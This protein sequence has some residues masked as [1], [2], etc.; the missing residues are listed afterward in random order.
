[1]KESKQEMSSIWH[2]KLLSPTNTGMHNPGL[3]EQAQLMI[4]IIKAFSKLL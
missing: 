1:M 4:I 3:L 2:L